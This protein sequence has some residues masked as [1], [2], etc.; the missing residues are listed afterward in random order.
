[1]AA[2]AKKGPQ[3][4]DGEVQIKGAAP[5]KKTVPAQ[6]IAGINGI[7][8]ADVKANLIDVRGSDYWRVTDEETGLGF[9]AFLSRARARR[10]MLLV[11]PLIDWTLPSAQIKQRYENDKEFR[12]A[13]KAACASVEA[14]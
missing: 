5:E 14:R 9:G 7:C 8:I 4:I 6:R 1:M 10:L 2:K 13:I 11:A 3:W 12:D